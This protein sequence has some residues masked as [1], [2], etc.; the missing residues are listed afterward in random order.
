MRCIKASVKLNRSYLVLCSVDR[1][2][3]YNLVNETTLVHNILYSQL[4]GVHITQLAVQNN[5]VPSVA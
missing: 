1:A 2:S 5:E 4:S 3:L